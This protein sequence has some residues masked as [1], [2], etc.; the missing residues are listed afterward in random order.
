MQVEDI[1]I[2]TELLNYTRV[3]LRAG[4]RVFMDYLD[5]LNLSLEDAQELTPEDFRALVGSLSPGQRKDVQLALSYAAQS[6]RLNLSRTIWET[7]RATPRRASCL[8]DE[9]LKL[10]DEAAR[11][12]SWRNRSLYYLIRDTGL[13]SEELLGMLNKH[14]QGSYILLAKGRTEKVLPISRQAQEAVGAYIAAKHDARPDAPLWP[15]RHGG[16][17]SSLTLASVLRQLSKNLDRV[18]KVE[19][20]RRTLIYKMVARGF[21]AD[22][23]AQWFGC[24]SVYV[25]RIAREEMPERR[26]VVTSA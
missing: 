13:T 1:L 23:I 21:P 22:L 2:D 18:V 10:M 17:I 12:A 11:Q 7:P 26:R 25:S 3:R 9:D 8:S 20:L 5:S 4:L 16:T 15:A 14:F 24:T 19:D 6:L